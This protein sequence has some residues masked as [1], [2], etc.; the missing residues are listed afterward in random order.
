MF[1]TTTL[2]LYFYFNYS[3]DVFFC[4]FVVGSKMQKIKQNNFVNILIFNNFTI[5][6]KDFRAILKLKKDL[7]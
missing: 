6:N 3:A 2:F 1:F 7:K 5:Q 4:T